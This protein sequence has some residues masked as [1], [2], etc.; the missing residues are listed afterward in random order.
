MKKLTVFLVILLI[1]G[2]LAGCWV[3][4]EPIPDPN[5]IPDPDPENIL[6]AEFTVEGWYNFTGYSV[7]VYYQI[8]NTGDVDINFFSVRFL[9]TQEDGNSFEMGAFVS[10]M[11]AYGIVIYWGPGC[12]WI[13]F[14]RSG[15]LG[16]GRFSPV[17]SV[18]VISWALNGVSFTKE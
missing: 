8:E 15:Y 9:V 2:L 14:A 1:V 7:D 12:K 5:P 10:G 11:T 16:P 3:T 6:A 17:V 13:T 4:P 18:E